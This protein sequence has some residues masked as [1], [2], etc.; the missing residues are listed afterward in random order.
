MTDLRPRLIELFKQRWPDIATIEKWGSFARWDRT[1]YKPFHALLDINTPEA[2]EAAAKMCVP[3]GW[4]IPSMGEN[5]E[6]IICMGD[7]HDHLGFWAVLQFRKSGGRL[8]R[9]EA[10]TLAEALV[11]AIERVMEVEGE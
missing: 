2:L 1:I 11:A 10:P 6:P 4:F 7:A 8:C 9:K 5:V 3:E